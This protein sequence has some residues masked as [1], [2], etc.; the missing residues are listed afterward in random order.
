MSNRILKLSAAAAMIV[1]MPTLAA[2]QT[3]AYSTSPV[4]VT[5]FSLSDTYTPGLPF[6]DG[7]RVPVGGDVALNFINNSNVPATSVTFM[8]NDGKTAQSI[9]DKGTFNPGVA[10][11]HTFAKDNVAS[12]GR[13]ATCNVAEVDFA[14]GSVWHAAPRD[15]AQR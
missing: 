8:L 7:T 1:A 12:A 3:V 15:V 4:A 14:D 5:S 6:L 13:N 9:V 11:D 10:I 2:A